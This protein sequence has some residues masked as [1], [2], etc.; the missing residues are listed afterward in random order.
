MR[1]S[2]MKLMMEV[3]LFQLSLVS[4]NTEWK[5]MID[6]WFR[7]FRVNIYLNIFFYY[8]NLVNLLILMN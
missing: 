3:S 7:K 8:V 4:K 2:T 5:H 6:T 1:T